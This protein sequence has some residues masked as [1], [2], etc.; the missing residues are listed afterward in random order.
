MLQQRGNRLR[1]PLALLFAACIALAAARPSLALDA[2]YTDAD[3]DLVAD[4]PAKTIDPS[5][6]IFSYTP[7]EDPSL[8]PFVWDDLIRHLQT[9]TGKAVRFYPAQSNVAQIEAMRAAATSSFD[10]SG[11]SAS[12][13][14][15]RTTPV[16][17][18]VGHAPRELKARSSAPGA[19]TCAPQT[20]QKNGRSAAT[21]IVGGT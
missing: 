20:G 6:L 8:F 21:S 10:G 1:P 12:S 5:T 17:A 3:G 9:A 15:V 14:T 4:V 19:S 2:R 16:P 18:H 7:G 11:T 13:S